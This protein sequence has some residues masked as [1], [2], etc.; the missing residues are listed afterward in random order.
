[1]PRAFQLPKLNQGTD[2][3]GSVQEPATVFPANSE[4]TICKQEW[5]GAEEAKR[6]RCNT[7]KDAGR[8]MPGAYARWD[9]HGCALNGSPAG[10]PLPLATW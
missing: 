4:R 3:G 7:G 2:S 8:E 5:A 6:Q 9:S 10:Q 1:M